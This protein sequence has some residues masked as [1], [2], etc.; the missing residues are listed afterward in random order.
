MEESSNSALF[1]PSYKKSYNV[2]TDV[3]FE[4]INLKNGTNINEIKHFN[5]KNEKS[6]KEYD[7]KNWNAFLINNVIFNM[8]FDDEIE[9]NKNGVEQ[10]LKKIYKLDS[11]L[12]KNYNSELE[13]AEN[14]I[15]QYIEDF[16]VCDIIKG[17]K[18]FIVPNIKN[19][20]EQQNENLLTQ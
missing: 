17:I 5:I 12:E 20:L 19:Q 6:F 15:K 8:I 9:L 11:E 14:D 3:I 16:K 1:N 7:K 13:K 4:N 10:T 2:I 18:K